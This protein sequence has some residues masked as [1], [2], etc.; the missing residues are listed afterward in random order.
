M[1]IFVIAA[2]T[3]VF[4]LTLGTFHFK[5]KLES[6]ERHIQQLTQHTGHKSGGTSM[7]TGEWINYNL[8]TFDSGRT[9][10]AIK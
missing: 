2:F 4:G 6:S 10:Y 5:D 7:L 8:K 3:L 9:W 1:H